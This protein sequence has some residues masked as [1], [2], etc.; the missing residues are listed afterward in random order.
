MPWTVSSDYKIKNIFKTVKKSIMWKPTVEI[1][2]PSS[3]FMLAV[4]YFWFSL[5]MYI[6]LLKQITLKNPQEKLFV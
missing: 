3:C 5:V 1:N 6:I 2:C 4:Q